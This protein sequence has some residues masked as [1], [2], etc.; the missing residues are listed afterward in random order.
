MGPKVD[1]PESPCDTFELL[2]TP[3][4]LN[5]IVEQSNLAQAAIYVTGSEKTCYNAHMAQCALLV[6]LVVLVVVVLTVKN[7]KVQ[8]M[9][10]NSPTNCCGCLRRVNVSYQGEISL[11]FDLPT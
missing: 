2:F 11:H 8:F 6:V 9:S 1:I 3:T 10:K 7:I 5:D 4:L